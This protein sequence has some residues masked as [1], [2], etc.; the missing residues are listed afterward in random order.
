MNTIGKVCLC[1]A[2]LL[3]VITMAPIPGKFGGWA[4]KLLVMHNQW[5]EKLRDSKQSVQKTQLSYSTSMQDL[6]KASTDLDNLMLGWGRQWDIPARTPELPD[7]AP[8]IG[9]QANAQLALHNIGAGSDPP[10]ATR[11]ITDKDGNQQLV[12]PVVHAFYSAGEGFVYAGEFVA[13]EIAAN[14]ALLQPVHRVLPE[15]SSAWPVNA[16]WRLRSLI[17]LDQRTAI[18]ELYRHERRTGELMNSTADNIE[19]QQELL[20]AAE[21]SLDT[22]RG[23]LLG[24]PDGDVLA[25]RPEFVEGLLKVTE[26]VE[27]ERNQLMLDVDSLRRAI[28]KAAAA[29]AAR[30]QRLNE[31]L[32]DL[33]Q[34]VPDTAESFPFGTARN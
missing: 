28:N 33:P 20:A 22:R 30:L 29:R 12:S 24:N 7:S 32:S 34:G 6:R 31:T 26:E 2:L 11:Q 25:E 17:P 18:D 27:E 13:V 14:S 21:A 9:K 1:L 16:A 19:R 23:E 3:L 4:P 15:E 5:S 10:L 8:R